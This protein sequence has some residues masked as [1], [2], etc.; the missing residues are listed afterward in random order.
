MSAASQAKRLS[1]AP[2]EARTKG[3]NFVNVRSFVEQHHGGAA[4]WDAVLA[5]MTGAD[6]EPLRA[7][8]AVGWYSL[9]LYA[10]LIRAVDDTH[11]QGDLSLVTEL[12]RF[13]AA[14]DLTTIH[15]VFLRLLNPVILLEKAAEYWHRHHD[16]GTWRIVRPSPNEA[17]GHLDG[18]GVDE[19]LCVELT[20]Y[21]ERAFQLAGARGLRFQHTACRACGDGRC[22][23]TAR[24]D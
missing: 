7:V 20:A 4:G 23:F 5:R 19:A 24:W 22:T 12:G 9:G 11:G 17:I 8:V 1:F 16:F 18:W 10:R 3:L 2:A 15:R 13:E 6:H 21:L 14:R